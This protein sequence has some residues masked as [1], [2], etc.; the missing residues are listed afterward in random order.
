MITPYP[1]GCFL[2]LGPYDL[3]SP[4]EILHFEDEFK[5]FNHKVRNRGLWKQRK[6][7]GQFVL[8]DIDVQDIIINEKKIR[9][10]LA[11]DVTEKIK[12]ENDLKNSFAQIRESLS[13]CSELFKRQQL[14]KI[15]LCKSGLLCQVRKQS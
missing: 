7:N 14:R 9:I 6:K 10:I 12:A 11:K 4:D 15:F 3:R 13:N 2:E 5:T 1:C 8:V